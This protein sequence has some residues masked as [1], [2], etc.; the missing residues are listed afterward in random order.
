MEQ[1][2]PMVIEDLQTWT[3]PSPLEERLLQDGYRSIFVA[4]LQYQ[5]NLLGILVLKSTRAGGLERPEYGQSGPGPALVRRGL[6]SQPGAVEP[7]DSNG[8]QRRVHGHPPFGGVAFSTSRPELY[9]AQGSPALRAG[10]H[11]F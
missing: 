8:H 5:D 10:T 7:K 6:K 11:C 2:E 3:D 1:K 4:P 9:S